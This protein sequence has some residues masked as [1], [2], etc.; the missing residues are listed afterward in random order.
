LQARVGSGDLAGWLADLDLNNAEPLWH[1]IQVEAGWE[2]AVET[3]LGHLLEAVVHDD[4]GSVRDAV[5]RLAQGRVALVDGATGGIDVPASSLAAKVQGPRAI[6]AL[7]APIHA[8]EALASGEAEAHRAGLR[9]GEA[10]IDRTGVW[11][12]PGWLR[13][14]KS[15]EAQQGALA[16]EREINELKQ[17]IVALAAREQALVGVQAIK[18]DGEKRFA[19][20]TAKRGSACRI[21]CVVVGEPVLVAEGYAT[22][23]TL[24]AAVG[25]RLPVFVA[26]DAGNL[27]PVVEILQAVYPQSPVLLCADDDYATE[28]NP[29]RAKAQKLRRRNGVHMIYPVWPGERRPKD[30]DFNDLHQAAGLHVVARQLR[31]PLAYLGYAVPAVSEARHAA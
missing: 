5:A 11:E 14:N 21:G 7:L 31:A 28:G 22:G 8:V 9:T 25:A 13:F 24:R 15:G 19:K 23:M 3:V 18:P 30:T 27:E 20:G 16:R 26:F 4:A 1:A 10:I 29:G 6:R 12:G 2:T 17:Q